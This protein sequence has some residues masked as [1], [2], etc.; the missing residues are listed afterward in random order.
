MSL[1][2]RLGK[3]GGKGKKILTEYLP[4][5]DEILN[6]KLPSL[7]KVQNLIFNC[8]SF[9]NKGEFGFRWIRKSYTCSPYIWILSFSSL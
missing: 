3:A 9:K 6:F 2:P 5:M 7:F 4:K 1:P 8:Q